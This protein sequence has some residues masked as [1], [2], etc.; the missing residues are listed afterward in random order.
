MAIY[1]EGKQSFSRGYGSLIENQ[2][3][4]NRFH[5]YI[6]STGAYYIPS[7]NVYI[8]PEYGAL[9]RASWRSIEEIREE[10]ERQKQIKPEQGQIINS[11]FTMEGCNLTEIKTPEGLHKLTGDNYLIFC[12]DYK[13]LLD[14]QLQSLRGRSNG[15]KL[16]KSNNKDG[17]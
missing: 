10:Q 7:E 1:F 8:H 13:G 4:S 12:K 6:L 15:A 11:I 17:K 9:V 3:K 16:T 14:E 5:D 2:K